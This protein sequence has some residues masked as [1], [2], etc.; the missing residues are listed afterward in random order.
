MIKLSSEKSSISNVSH[1]RIR[2]NR[3][4]GFNRS[5]L[6]RG[7]KEGKSAAEV[8]EELDTSSVRSVWNAMNRLRHEDNARKQPFPERGEKLPAIQE[9]SEENTGQASVWLNLPMY[10]SSDTFEVLKILAK[11]SSWSEHLQWFDS[12]TGGGLYIYNDTNII[13]LKR[14]LMRS[15]FFLYLSSEKLIPRDKLKEVT[16]GVIPANTSEGVNQNDWADSLFQVDYSSSLEEL[17]INLMEFILKGKAR[18]KGSGKEASVWFNPDDMRAIGYRMQ[19]EGF[20]FILCLDPLASVKYGH[21]RIALIHGDEMVLVNNMSDKEISALFMKIMM[22]PNFRYL[23]K[24]KMERFDRDE[25]FRERV[26]YW[27]GYLPRESREEAIK[28]IRPFSIR[29]LSERNAIIGKFGREH[30]NRL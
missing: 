5:I 28:M 12:S 23:G 25:S 4:K 10:V 20:Y 30:G 22:E 21:C 16:I 6:L 1:S 3:G 26:G 2:K 29:Y 7:I 11:E 27:V 13:N 17:R 14:W 15:G 24:G 18:F 9:P 19:E 8:A